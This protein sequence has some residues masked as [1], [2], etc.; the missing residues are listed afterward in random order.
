MASTSD[1]DTP[2][3][4]GEIIALPVAAATKINGGTLV[5][6]NATGYA[7]PATKAAALKILGRAEESADNTAGAAG[8]VTV[9]ARRKAVF[10]YANS[11]SDSLTQADV[12]GT[13]YAEDDSTVCKTATGASAVGKI[14]GVEDDGVWVEIA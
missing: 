2:L 13:A 1:I 3:K 11:A 10:K 12:G 5:A 8:A 9:L 7:A 6:L 4:A 14:L